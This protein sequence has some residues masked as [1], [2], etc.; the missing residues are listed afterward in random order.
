MAQTL[1]ENIVGK[2]SAVR[3][4]MD[5]IT[6][7]KGRHVPLCRIKNKKVRKTKHIYLKKK[8]VIVYL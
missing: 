4:A 1:K 6:T 3:L 8:P 7:E 2:I 5:E